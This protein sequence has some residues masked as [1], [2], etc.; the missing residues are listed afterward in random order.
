[1]TILSE[2]TALEKSLIQPIGEAPFEETSLLREMRKAVV[3]GDDEISLILAKA[4]CEKFRRDEVSAESCIVYCRV[5]TELQA[6]CDGLRRQ[7]KRCSDFARQKDYWITSIFCEVASGADPLP[8][9][10]LVERLAI[11]QQCIV[12][13]ED[14]ARWSRRGIADAPPPFVVMVS[15][16][17]AELDGQIREALSRHRSATA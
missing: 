8:I 16:T 14:Y 4:F 13:C 9:R 2:V 1:M 6:V 7:L 10:A 3:R 15:K 5:S 11:K 12:L 17:S